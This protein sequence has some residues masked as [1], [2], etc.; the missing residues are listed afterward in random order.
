[1]LKLIRSIQLFFQEGNSDKVYEIELLESGADA[2]VVNFRYGRRGGAL[3]D[4]TKTV[5]PV[6][7]AEAEKLFAEL[8]NEK[9]KKGYAPEGENANFIQE[10]KPLKSEKSG[11][12]RHKAIVKLLKAALND[13]EHESWPVSRIIW[14]AGELGIPEA[15]PLILKLAD[16][17]DPLQ[18]YSCIWSLSRIGDSAAVLFLNEVLQDKQPGYILN[19][20]KAALLNISDEHTQAAELKKLWQAFPESFRSTHES[21]IAGVNATGRSLSLDS[22]NDPKASFLALS[23]QASSGNPMVSEE[24]RQGI[25]KTEAYLNAYVLELCTKAGAADLLFPAYLISA[26]D[27]LM[28]AAL[29]QA[30]KQVPVKAGFFKYVR[31][32]FK[33]SEMLNDTEVYGILSKVI[34]KAPS[35]FT[36][37]YLY[38]DRKWVS[39][40]EEL[41]KENSTLAFS[42]KTKEYFSR[43]ILRTLRKLGTEQSPLYTRYA[44]EILLN[45]DDELDQPKP[46]KSS[47]TYYRYDSA[48]RNYHVTTLTSWYDIYANYN[49]FYYILY[50]NSPRYTL[51]PK[52]GRW[53]CVPPYE[54]GKAFEPLREE[55]FAVLW[56]K[57]P[58]DI[59]RLLTHSRCERVTDFA[60]FVFKNNAAFKEQVTG[61]HVFAFLRSRFVNVQQLGFELVK[62]LYTTEAPGAM[63]IS[64][65]LLSKL[66]EARVYAQQFVDREPSRYANDADLVTGIILSENYASQQWLMAF[67]LQHRPQAETQQTVFK[68][69]LD[70]IH[71]Q[72]LSGKPE[73]I[74]IIGNLIES[75]FKELTASLNPKIIFDLLMHVDPA[76]QGMAGKLLVLRK[77]DPEQVP[78]SIIFTLLQSENTMARNAAIDL[79][80]QLEAEAILEKQSLVLSLCLSPLQDLRQSAQRLMDKLL[81]ADP[82]SGYGLVKL[83]LPVLA[84]KEK[85]DG[86]HDDILQLISHKLRNFL[87]RIEP[88]Q[89]LALCGSR[90]LASQEL[91]YLL[92]EKNINA[93]ELP[94]KS[95]NKLADSNLQKTRAYVM[96]YYQSHAARMKYEREDS[97]MLA[98]GLWEDVRRFAFDFFRTNFNDQDWQPEMFVALCDSNK[99]DVQAY[100]R[101]MITRWFEKDKGFDYLLKLSQHP[102]SRMQLFA[103]GFLDQ[104]AKNNYEM[105]QKLG[106]FLIT[107]LSQVNKGHTAKQRAIKLLSTE[108][109]ASEQNAVLISAIFNRMSATASIMDKALYIKAMLEISKAFPSVSLVLEVKDTEVYQSKRNDHAVQL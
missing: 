72:V 76:I 81:A 101:E 70:A 83:F 29:L 2:Y 23:K 57:A 35:N 30:L 90:Y 86:L 67:L 28:R 78:D 93:D 99:A 31:Q 104:Y 39:A 55:A 95:L 109:L 33:M 4:G 52:K 43:R 79:L 36:S 34:E 15:A 24:L 48:T 73:Q 44:T 103:S 68:N 102:D 19:L 38:I 82:S 9:R 50:A 64:A 77:L 56:N 16:K 12:A 94:V 59:I 11:S 10:L 63:I 37:T 25:R 13:D 92:L 53:E 8:E 87:D 42:K 41:K 46:D 107:L 84:E 32:I 60:L 47:K 88:K 58:E 6:P 100:G 5:F 91:G 69:L 62:Q 49:A 75:C 105:L 22:G 89:V 71:A 20:A 26:K 51:K 21:N 66:D 17:K 40:S 18:L 74:T 65:L 54:P 27:E 7:L 3:K 98:D 106:G 14:R 61:E 80:G 96:D 1:M 85:H 45:F 108:A 97:I